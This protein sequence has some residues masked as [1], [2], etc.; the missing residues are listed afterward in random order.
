[1]CIKAWAVWHKSSP[2]WKTNSLVENEYFT[3]SHFVGVKWRLC[4][5]GKIFF[6]VTIRNATFCSPLADWALTSY[7]DKATCKYRSM[8]LLIWNLACRN[9]TF[10]FIFW[11]IV[12]LIQGILLRL[13]TNIFSRRYGHW[14]FAWDVITNAWLHVRQFKEKVLSNEN[15][16]LEF[17][18]HKVHGDRLR[19]NHFGIKYLLSF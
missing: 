19:Y 10:I 11:Y 15:I 4:V 1:M 5:S 2:A 3:I 6:S 14:I 12:T 8:Q 9:Q 16:C 13:L 17:L 18:R 7:L